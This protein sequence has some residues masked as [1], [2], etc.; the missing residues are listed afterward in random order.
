MGDPLGVSPQ[1]FGSSFN[2]PE[3]VRS[4]IDP[5]GSFVLPSS[6]QTE[7]PQPPPNVVSVQR[8]A[9]K[10]AS[11]P[12]SRLNQ[13]FE[14]FAKTLGKGAVGTLSTLCVV[15]G[16]I[17]AATGAAITTLAWSLGAGAGAGIG[18]VGGVIKGAIQGDVTKGV[19]E[20]ALVGAKYGGSAL[21]AISLIVSVPCALGGGVAAGGGILGLRAVTDTGLVTAEQ[22]IVERKVKKLDDVAAKETGIVVDFI[23]ELLLQNWAEPDSKLR[24]AFPWFQPKS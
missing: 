22:G 9:L 11:D 24:Q 2:P 23:K 17:T 10:A 1:N 12:E 13:V 6:A 8:K 14:S 20:G 5:I 18:A 19:K 7:K 4:S 21:G 15:A 16:G 3:T